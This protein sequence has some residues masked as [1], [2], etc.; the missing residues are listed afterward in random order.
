MSAT[1]FLIKAYNAFL[2][3]EENVRCLTNAV[4]VIMHGDYSAHDGHLWTKADKHLIAAGGSLD[5]LIM[6]NSGTHIALADFSF[7]ATKGPNDVFL[8]ENPFFNVSSIGV[9]VNSLF[10]SHNRNVNH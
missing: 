8:Y 9:D 10:S 7:K 3:R 4:K 5:H 1:P 2:G 6:P